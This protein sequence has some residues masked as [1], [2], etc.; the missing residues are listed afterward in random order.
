MART[1]PDISST[2]SPF[3]RRPT[4]NAAICAGVARPSSTSTIAAPACTEV[5]SSPRVTWPSSEGQP[6]SSSS[7][8]VTVL[9]PPE[10]AVE[11]TSGDQPEL[12][13][14]GP[15]HDRELPSVPIPL[16]GGVVLHV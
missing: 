1:S 3:M 6:P 7:V 10:I 15:L 2:V 8:I 16:L 9:I 12:H 5:R 4:A 13:L 14:G 11:H